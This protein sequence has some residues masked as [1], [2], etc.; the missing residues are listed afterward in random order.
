MKGSKERSLLGQNQT[1]S[2]NFRGNPLC[3][4]TEQKN[5]LSDFWFIFKTLLFQDPKYR[6]V[7][8]LWWVPL[9]SRGHQMQVTCSTNRLRARG[10]VCREPR[11]SLYGIGHGS[12]DWRQ[13]CVRSAVGECDSKSEQTGANRDQHSPW[14]IQQER[15]LAQKRRLF[16]LIVNF[17][18]ML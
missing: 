3:Q 15:S 7:Q 10:G 2:A 5:L 18:K 6:L 12:H 17:T 13:A 14:N 4:A 16:L 8:V 11:N 9:H 1:K